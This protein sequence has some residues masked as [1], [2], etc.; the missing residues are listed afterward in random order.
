M[1]KRRIF[2]ELT[3]FGIAASVFA[4]V[5]AAYIASLLGVS[6][7]VIGAAV[8]SFTA[9]LSA[10]IYTHGLNRAAELTRRKALEEQ[11]QIAEAEG[12]PEGGEPEPDPIHWKSVAITS[13]I[14]LAITMSVVIGYEIAT[15]RSFGPDDQGPTVITQIVERPASPSPTP[16]TP[17]PSVVPTLP[18]PS[19]P[20]TPSPSP[21][22]SVSLEPAP[23]TTPQ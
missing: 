15:G 10:A 2:G 3:P 11:I 1:N 18:S 16:P 14:V 20:V 4:A 23:E 17:T 5:T 8:A 7:T 13:V 22:P 6:G 19:A 9:T 21:S 12:M